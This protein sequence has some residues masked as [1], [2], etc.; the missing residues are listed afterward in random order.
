M[1][2]ACVGAICGCQIFMTV[3]ATSVD[4]PSNTASIVRTAGVVYAYAQGVFGG[5]PQTATG[6][7]TTAIVANITTVARSLSVEANS[8]RSSQRMSP[9]NSAAASNVSHSPRFS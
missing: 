6:T 9:V 8:R 1:S 3:N 7:S 5:A 4:A 2:V